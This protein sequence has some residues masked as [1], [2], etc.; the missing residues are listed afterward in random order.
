MSDNLIFSLLDKFDVIFDN[1]VLS[2]EKIIRHYLNFL[3]EKFIPENHSVNVSLHTGDPAFRAATIASLLVACLVS[4]KYKSP[5]KAKSFNPG[6]LVIYRT[7]KYRYQGI[8]ADN[9]IL[10]KDGSTR[11]KSGTCKTFVPIDSID[12]IQRYH[13]TSAGTERRRTYKSSAKTEFM[14]FVLG[15]ND[16]SLHIP[17][18]FSIIVLSTRKDFEEICSRLCIRYDNKTIHFTEI[19]PATYYT[20]SQKTYQ[21]GLNPEKT[22]PIIKVTDSMRVCIKIINDR[23]SDNEVLG[24]FI[25]D[26]RIMYYCSSDLESIH[27]NTFFPLRFVFIT[28]PFQIFACN[29]LTKINFLEGMHNDSVF[30]CTA[31]YLKINELN[32]PVVLSSNYTE[33][34]KQ[35]LSNIISKNITVVQVDNYWDGKI[36]NDVRR[37]IYKIGNKEWARENN[38][39][40]CALG[41]YRLFESSFFGFCEFDG[42]TKMINDLTKIVDESARPPQECRAVLDFFNEV[43][44]GFRDSTP[45]GEALLKILEEHSSEKTALI[46]PKKDFVKIFQAMYGK[47]FKNVSCFYFKNF[48]ATCTYDL[49]ISL[50]DHNDR[51]KHIQFDVFQCCSTPKFII[52]LYDFEVEW[53]LKRKAEIQK[54]ENYLNYIAGI[55]TDIEEKEQDEGQNYVC[56][57]D[58]ITVNQDEVQDDDFVPDDAILDKIIDLLDVDYSYIKFRNNTDDSNGYVEISRIGLLS[59]GAK[60]LFSKNYRAVVWDR[61]SNEVREIHVSDITVGDELIFVKND[62]YAKNMV[63]FIFEKLRDENLLDDK[64]RKSREQAEQWR[65]ALRN[66]HKSHKTYKYADIA[67]DLTKDSQKYSLKPKRYDSQTVRQWLIDDSYI[68]GPQQEEDYLTIARVTRDPDLSE[69][70]KGCHE[71]CRAVRGFRGKIRDFMKKAIASGLGN[72]DCSNDPIIRMIHE[73]IQ[74][75]AETAEL[76]KI[77]DIAENRYVNTG[78]ANRFIYDSEE[79]CY[80]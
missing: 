48:D 19:L 66:Y 69:D 12:D 64:I 55:T 38:F 32:S 29:L 28:I 4:I 8:E 46:V 65:T 27:D 26:P 63:D 75:L 58:D 80:E 77:K 36:I 70:P 39:I 20:E 13:G 61:D 71:A 68:I 51:E 16:K 37:K 5:A 74:N 40:L 17:M 7:E 56:Q 10:E 54:T 72:T 57:S 33:A 52:I 41:L 49:I 1:E 79:L 73:N 53:F 2:R 3:A 6:E 59:N 67:H 15:L 9:V 22:E 30:F 11:K 35:H 43:S 50:K 23:D 42:A 47:R 78:K 31:D 24:L 76:V 21:I 18:N 62:S 14:S 34:L 25:T 60:I 44:V 45:K